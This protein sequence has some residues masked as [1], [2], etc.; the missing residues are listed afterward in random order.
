MKL[1]YFVRVIVRMPQ[2]P[3]QSVPLDFVQSLAQ[4][5]ESCHS[6]ELFLRTD[7]I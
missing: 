1:L 6:S 7:I 4:T 2:L 3:L 5:K